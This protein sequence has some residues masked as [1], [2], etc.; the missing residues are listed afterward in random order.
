MRRKWSQEEN[1][2]VMQCNYRSEYWRN[3]Y[4]KRMHVIWNEMGMFNVTAKVGW[5]EE[6]HLEE[7]MTVRFRTGR[8]TKK[9][10]GYQKWWSEGGK[11]W[12]WGMVFGIWL[13]RTWCVYERMWS[14]AIRLHGAKHRE[15]KKQCFC[16]R[17]EYANYEWGHDHSWKKAL[18]AIKRDKRKTATTEGNWEA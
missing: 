4:K 2:V 17:D 3:G 14:C 1:R 9:H 12:R 13:R 18:Y 11:W 8:N 16:N 10:W 7:K 6:Y 5:S 15:G